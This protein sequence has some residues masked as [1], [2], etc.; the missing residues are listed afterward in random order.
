METK[1]IIFIGPQGSGKGTQ[2]KKVT[3]HLNQTDKEVICLQTGE[4]FRAMMKQ[5][6]LTAGLVKMIMESGN[7]VPNWLVVA[8][9]ANELK[10]RLKAETHLLFD[11]FPRNLEQADALEDIISFYK[12]TELTVVYLDISEA[13]IRQRLEDRLRSDDVKQ[14]I[15]RRLEL[16]H[17]Y[18]KPVIDYYKN[19][20]KTNFV[21][22]DGT[23][24]VE[25]VYKNI[26]AVLDS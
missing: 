10:D 22:V 26:K 17:R 15:D 6:S 14:I 16:Y 3:N 20:S 5:S 1:T 23:G 2:I 12:R 13:I 8:T 24:S 21:G 9:V 19:R 18:T 4:L 11:G 25:E 7:L